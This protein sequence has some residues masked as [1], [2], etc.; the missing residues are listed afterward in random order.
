MHIIV[1][2]TRHVNP[3]VRSLANDLA[4]VLPDALRIN[5]GK[6]N[7]SDLAEIA[8]AYNAR[9]VLIVGKGLQGNPGR[10]VFLTV[11]EYRYSFY[12]LIISL[13]GVKLARELNIRP[14]SVPLESFSVATLK[15]FSDA[16][17]EL[18]LAL[19]E[20]LQVNYTEISN[21]NSLT[22]IF[23]R[24]LFIEETNLEKNPFLIRFVKPSGKIDGPLLR[25]KRVVYR[26]PF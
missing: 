11:M 24:I 13:T 15:N 22:H 17:K 25:V 19:S 14:S 4:H 26:Q 21:L 6:N 16:T 2:T 20:A 23:D 5:R 1:T 18:A 7:I 10:L 3:R 8:R 12:P 9:V